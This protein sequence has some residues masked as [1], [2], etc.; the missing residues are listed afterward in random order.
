M[1]TSIIVFNGV[2]LTNQ[3]YYLY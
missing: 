2:S 1:I 3:L